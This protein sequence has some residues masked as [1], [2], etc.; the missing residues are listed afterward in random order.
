LNYEQFKRL[1]SEPEGE[2]LEF[3]SARSTIVMDILINYSI[4]LANEGGGKLVLGV[5]DARPRKIVGTQV[6]L[7]GISKI[8]ERL[9]SELRLRIDIEENK[10][11]EGRVLIFHI[12]SRPIG[13][14]LHRNGQYFMRAG[15]SLVGM[16]PDMIK[17]IFDEAGP[18]YSVETVP[19]ARVDDLDP[20]AIEAFRKRWSEKAERP[21]LVAIPQERL[22]RD[23]ELM[24][25]G[26][27]TIAAL[28]LFGKREALGRLR[29]AHAEVI[30]EYRAN[31]APGPAQQREE[32]RQGFFSF[33][34]RLWELIDLRNTKQSFQDG[35]FML[36]IKTFNEGAIREAILNAVSHRDYRSGA[37][38]FVR[39]YPE[40]IEIT[41]PGGP[42][43]GITIANI[44][45]EQF[46]RNRRIAETFARAGLVER[47]GQGMNRIF[48][49][50]IRETK[51]EPDFTH[52]DADHFWI[53]LHGRIQHP[54]FLQVLEKI[55]RERMLSF[56]A[57]DFL[58]LQMIY[59]EKLVP[60]ALQYIVDR[61]LEEGIAERTP[62]GKGKTVI[63]SRKLY[64][65]IGKD[66]VHTRK[67]GLDR[68]TQKE[69]LL[70]HIQKTE[71]EGA[72]MEELLQVL[73]MLD[74]HAV[75]SLLR[76]LKAEK[77]VVVEG[78]TNA[79]RW[80]TVGGAT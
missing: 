22:L 20:L 28:V 73:P 29:L 2:H 18:D 51:P 71:P 36:D 53:T 68:E 76:S 9:A 74:R 25:G 34:N 48:A 35:F 65:A 58:A 10:F 80:H 57:D 6:F 40:R 43:P 17:R 64:K 15:E 47:S 77:K 55:G 7:D 26:Q 63:L 14:P 50:C 61:F 11:S 3:K 49:S 56:S 69:L 30:F 38:V 1:L 54:E 27:L 4:A 62:T 78:V 31:D 12:P 75:G 33:Y 21:D 42:P 46:P 16:T 44:L 5:S 24:V 37:S 19:G 59:D 79:A 72:R 8:K 60:P 67:K 32:F 52:T 23:S 13:T 70:R 45:N 66:G 39:Q 41:N